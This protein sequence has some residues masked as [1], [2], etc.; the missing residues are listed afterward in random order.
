MKSLMGYMTL[1]FLAILAIIVRK[2]ADAY[3][4][5]LVILAVLS[6]NDKK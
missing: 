5:G 3:I 2:P 4:A 6:T 1:F